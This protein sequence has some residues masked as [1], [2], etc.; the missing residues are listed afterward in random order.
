MVA[1]LT[2]GEGTA[3]KEYLISEKARCLGRDA[4]ADVILDDDQVSNLH[5]RIMLNGG[6]FKIEDLGSRNGTYVN[7]Q[8]CVD[9]EELENGDLIKIGRTIIKFVICG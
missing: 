5:T 6:K 4:E 3:Q 7:G 8:R 2:W 9:D 1:H